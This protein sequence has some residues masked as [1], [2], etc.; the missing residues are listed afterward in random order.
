MNKMRKII[1]IVLIVMLTLTSCGGAKVMYDYDKGVDF[2]QYK[3]Y[4][5]HPNMNINTISE[6]DGKRILNAIED[7]LRAKGFH[8]SDTPELYVDVAPSNRTR[9]KSAGSIGV[10]L[11]NWGRHFGV[12]LGTSVPLTKK[13]QDSNLT[14]EMID[15]NSNQMIWQGIFEDTTSAKASPSQKEMIFNRSVRELLVNF[16]PQ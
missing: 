15:A 7:Q 9:N 13:V 2:S 11:G 4:N 5:F 14:L 8:K 3:T 1:G 6:L 12:N 10:G 16:P